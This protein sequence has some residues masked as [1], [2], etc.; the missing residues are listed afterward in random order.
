MK[1]A[2]KSK[3]PSAPKPDNQLTWNAVF[4]KIASAVELQ[5]ARIDMLNERFD[6]LGERYDRKLLSLRQQNDERAYTQALT[7]T[8]KPTLMWFERGSAAISWHIKVDPTTLILAPGTTLRYDLVHNQLTTFDGITVGYLG[9]YDW[10][11]IT[12]AVGPGNQ[13]KLHVYLTTSRRLGIKLG[14][15]A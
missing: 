13:N 10:D 15:P 6:K 1:T 7:P 4:D 14:R 12:R 8:P 5:S 11:E 2:K 3:S 9:Q